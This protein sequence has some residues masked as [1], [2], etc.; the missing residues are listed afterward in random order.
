M[1]R[2][3]EAAVSWHYRCP[4]DRGVLAWADGAL[5][6]C[7]CGTVFPVVNGVPVL[8]NDANSVFRCSDFT[9]AAA[10]TGAS[11]YGGTADPSTG[12]K[13][14]YRAFARRLSEARVPGSAAID[15]LYALLEADPASR[16][17]VIGAG[18]RASRPG[19][20]RTDV[21][22]AANVDCVCDAHDLPFEDGSFDVVYAESVLEHVCDPQRCVAEITRVLS[23]TGR[24]L[25]VTPFLQPVHMGAYDFTR[26]THMGHRRLF[27]MYDEIG[28]GLCGGPAYAAIHILRNAVTGL[29]DNHRARAML[30][31]IM[32]LLTYPWR[33][34]DPWL[35]RTRAAYNVGCAFYFCGTK[36]TTP[37]PDRDILRSFQ[38]A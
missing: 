36:R 24:V 31:L 6:C 37:I 17:L 32:L 18:E 35:S 27:R 30:R 9:S 12:L 38:G 10:Y 2:I 16:I 21:A 14:A 20:V 33:Y 22:F 28:S 5:I 13:R 7:T 34:L 23:P 19:T 8:I 11:G 26:F 4:V 29:T 15:R 25:A 3:S 1:A